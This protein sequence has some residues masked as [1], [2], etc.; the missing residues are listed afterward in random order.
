VVA[1]VLIEA[2]STKSGWSRPSSASTRCERVRAPRSS[3]PGGRAA[4]RGRRR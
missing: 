3:L 4:A 2:S 1:P